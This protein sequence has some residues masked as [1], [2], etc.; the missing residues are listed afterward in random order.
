M[1]RKQ[2]QDAKEDRRKK[3][4]QKKTKK[5]QKTKG[6]AIPDQYPPQTKNAKENYR[7][8]SG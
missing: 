7:F 3:K 6:P 4:N 2:Q 8:F 5:D 1:P